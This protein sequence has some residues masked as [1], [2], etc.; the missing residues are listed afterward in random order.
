MMYIMGMW[1][2]FGVFAISRYAKYHRY[3]VWAGSRVS[4]S[5]AM[6]FLK[7]WQNSHYL[8][9]WC[10]GHNVAENVFI[11]GG[12]QGEKEGT[13]E[14][15]KGIRGCHMSNGGWTPQKVV[16][17]G[18]FGEFWV[19]FGK[20]HGKNSRIPP[21]QHFLYF[22]RGYAIL[23]EGRLECGNVEIYEGEIVHISWQN[24]TTFLTQMID[25]VL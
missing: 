15:K 19:V 12:F 21:Q 7:N 4:D 25:G 2:L 13:R 14:R 11:D 20:L 24:G 5:D 22:H 10:M 9:G 23:V 18:G 17:V 8:A 3:R 6:V 1:L 16:L